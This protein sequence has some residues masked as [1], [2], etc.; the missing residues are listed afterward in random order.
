VLADPGRPTTPVV[1]SC[2]I[3][4]LWAY[5]RIV[6]KNIGEVTVPAGWKAKWV[7]EGR[8]L[9]GPKTY[10]GVYV[11]QDDLEPG[12]GRAIDVNISPYT[13]VDTP[14]VTTWVN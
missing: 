7:V 9:L 6:F 11:F 4:M 8:D 3:V 14:C 2:G 1:V 5:R 10:S 12:A 13:A